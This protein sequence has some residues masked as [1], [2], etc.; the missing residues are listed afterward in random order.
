[1]VI[2][3]LLP[4]YYFFISFERSSLELPHTEP[5]NPFLLCNYK[6]DPGKKKKKTGDGQLHGLTVFSVIAQGCDRCRGVTGKKHT[7][8]HTPKRNSAS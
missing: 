2:F 7:G 5:E 8:W 4:F 1:M 6:E 3:F